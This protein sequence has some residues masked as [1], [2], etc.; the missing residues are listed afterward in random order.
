MRKLIVLV[1]TLV[2]IT[3][4]FVIGTNVNATT[5][6]ERLLSLINNYR[7]S[8]GLPVLAARNDVAAVAA[9]H[10]KN[11]HDQNNLNHILDG[12][13]PSDRLN[14]AG[15]GYTAMCENV[16]FNKGYSDPVQICFDGWVNSPGHNA[17]M[18]SSSVT[19]AGIGIYYSD[20]K[21]WWFT[22]MGIKPTGDDQ[23]D[24]GDGDEED[25]GDSQDINLTLKQ[26]TSS[27]YSITFTNTGTVALTMKTTIVS[28]SKWVVA[29]PATVTIPAGKK[30]IFTV[31]ISA[32]SDMTPGKYTDTVK[33]SWNGGASNYVINLTVIQNPDLIKPDFQIVGPDSLTIPF[34]QGAWTSVNLTV[35]NTGSTEI[36]PVASAYGNYTGLLKLFP[37]SN[38]KTGTIKPGESTTIDIGIMMLKTTSLKNAIAYFTFTEKTIKKTLKITLTRGNSPMFSISGPQLIK[39]DFVGKSKTFN[40]SITNTGKTKTTFDIG[41]WFD[42]YDFLTIDYLTTADETPVE[43]GKT[44]ALKV[45]INLLKKPTVS[46]VGGY[47]QCNKTGDTTKKNLEFKLMK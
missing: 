12:K 24:P 43:A 25:E 21:G 47:I 35:K 5:D 10:S 28:G 40:Y 13:S 44:V 32:F 34:E 1:T 19:H 15:I 41:I 22:F 17:N 29:T 9:A 2:F 45:T 7:Q 37:N 31:K 46:F 26:G 3:S 33:F 4:T 42:N 23:S 8:N 39:M 6:Q 14:D 38:P 20:A 30:Q 36:N 18:L 11:M 27:S 16:A